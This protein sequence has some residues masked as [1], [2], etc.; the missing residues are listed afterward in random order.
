MLIKIYLSKNKAIPIAMAKTNMCP[1]KFLPNNTAHGYR[2]TGVCK[3]ANSK[4]IKGSN[5]QICV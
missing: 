2:N 3:S 1:S 4:L 5:E